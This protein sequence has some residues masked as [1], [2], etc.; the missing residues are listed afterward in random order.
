MKKY[1]FIILLVGVGLGQIEPGEVIWEENF[2]NLE[3]L[4]NRNV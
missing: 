3:K 1:L 2:D 4:D